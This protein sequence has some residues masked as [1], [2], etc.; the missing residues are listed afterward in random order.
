[1]KN[2]KNLSLTLIVALGSAFI[3]LW[4]YTQFFNTPQIVRIEENQ[5]MHYASLPSAPQG[6]A[7]D[8]TFAAENSVH[9]V[10][11]VKV[12]STENAIS[13][14]NPFY[15]WFYGDRY[16]RQEPRIREGSGSGVIISTDGY[17]VTNNHVIDKA[18]QIKVV[19]NDKREFEAKLI[20]IDKT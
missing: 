6:V 12:I 1:M 16:Q 2:V 11:H 7:P 15:D 18:D 17:I 14:N 4:V 19:L 3:T 9:A 20:G 13:Y 10:V 5:A 8:L